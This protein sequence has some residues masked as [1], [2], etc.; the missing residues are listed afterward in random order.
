MDPPSVAHRTLVTLA[1][2]VV[3]TAGLWATQVIVLPFLFSVMV[4]VV[5]APVVLWLER[6]RVPSWLAVGL[7]VVGLMGVLVAVGTVLA[8]SASEFTSAMPRY[9]ER[10]DAMLRAFLSWLSASLD[11]DLSP[12]QLYGGI[13]I[14]RV[15]DAVG[16]TLNGVLA[17]LTNTTL[18]VLTLVFILLEVTE[19]PRKIRAVA[20]D[21]AWALGRARTMVFEVQRYLVIKT[22]ISAVTG[23]LL[24]VWTGVLGVDFPLLW[25]FVAFILNFIPNIGSIL[26]A[27]PPM[28]VALVQLGPGYMVLVAAGYLAVNMVLGNFVEPQWM[29]RKLGL[30]PLVVFLSLLFWGWLWGG[31]GMLLSVPLTMV[32][33]ILCE[34]SEGLRWIATLLSGAPEIEQ[35]EALRAARQASPGP[36]TPPPP[37]PAA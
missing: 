26:A 15:I 29:G 14:G 1:A 24:G 5:A 2:L 13:E 17:A 21:P 4:A 3:V 20:G 18:V 34:Q 32:I 11:V 23:V 16:A 30:S 22:V 25:G 27:F 19:L 8:A 37:P 28:V 6:R 33:K 9:K 35:Q 7:V 10:L 31:V 36:P 12:E